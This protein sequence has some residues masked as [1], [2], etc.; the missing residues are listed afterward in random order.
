MRCN[1][2]DPDALFV[3]A[4]WSMYAGFGIERPT[5]CPAES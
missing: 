4:L 2:Y 5:G 1:P 3:E